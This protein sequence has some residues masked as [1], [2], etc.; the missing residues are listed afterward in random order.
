MFYEE[1]TKDD[2]AAG[3]QKRLDNESLTEKEMNQFK[4]YTLIALGEMYA[5]KGWIMQLHL[6]ALRN[7]NTRMFN[8]VGPDSG[9][10][11]IGDLLIADKLSGLDRKST[12]LNSSH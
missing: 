6:G 9:F 3:F 10:D 2:V 1:G 12:R 7:N 8:K 4:T 11:S 5:E